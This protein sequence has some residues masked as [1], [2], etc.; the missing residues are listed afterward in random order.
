M[1]P[2]LFLVEFVSTSVISK[3]CDD[4]VIC[5]NAWQVALA[6][7]VDTC[8]HRSSCC[9]PKNVGDVNRARVVSVTC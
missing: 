7:G 1:C 2:C 5:D 3:R 6:G 9:V 8:W 4:C